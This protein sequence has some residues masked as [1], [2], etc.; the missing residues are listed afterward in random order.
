M[1]Q[2]RMTNLV[3]DIFPVIKNVDQQIDAV[4]DLEINGR[5]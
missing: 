5:A 3:S 4:V 2:E 1:C